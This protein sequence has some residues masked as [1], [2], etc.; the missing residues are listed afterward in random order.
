[1]KTGDDLGLSHKLVDL[2]L[3]M[4]LAGKPMGIEFL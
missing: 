1:M 4:M 3:E 2:D